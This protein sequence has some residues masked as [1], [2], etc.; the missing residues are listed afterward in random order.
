MLQRT[1]TNP[2]R[3]R[4]FRLLLAGQGL[5][6]VGDWL[7]NVALIALVYERTGS[8]AWLGA[9]TAARVLPIVLL[10]PVAGSLADRFDRRLVMIICDAVRAVSMLAL[11]GVATAGLPVLAAPVLAALATAAS[12]PYPSCVAATVPRLLARAELTTANALRSALGSGAVVLGPVI[13][14]GVLAAG[15]AAWAFA[16]NALTFI[17]AAALTLAVRQADAFRPTGACGPESPIGAG[18]AAVLAGVVAGTLAG[19]RELLRRPEAARLVGADVLCSV[20]YGVQTVTLVA[21][22]AQLGWDA[23]GYG[24]LLAAIGVGGLAGASLTPWLTRRIGRGAAQSVALGTVAVSLPLLALVPSAPGVLLVAAGN[25]AGALAVEVCTE[26]A[27]A[28]QLPDEVFA[29]AYG[30]AFPASIAGI[31]LGSVLAGPLT[32]ALG[33]PGALLL[34]AGVLAGYL[35]RTIAI[36][37]REAES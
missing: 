15:G 30:F 37:A 25:G 3:H 2:L 34:V 7:Y 13:G 32:T 1:A 24:V 22:A 26:T 18:F 6:Q 5:S 14:A 36:T 31:A 4:D 28:E 16:A 23:G 9:T 35:V 27:L 19:A 10:G 29:R 21:V 20:V 17:G 8:A 12:S 11:V 33:L